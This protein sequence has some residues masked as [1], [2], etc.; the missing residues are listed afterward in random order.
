[1][2]E[3]FKQYGSAIITVVSIIAVIA[4]I[5]LVIGA[6]TNSII[7]KAFSDLITGFYTKA[8]SAAGL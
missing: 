7:Y 8:S 4:I 2:E 3:I 5:A 6:D 1:M